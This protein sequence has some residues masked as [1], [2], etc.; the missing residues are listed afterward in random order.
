MIL[1]LILPR[2]GL[3]NVT[4]QHK[5]AA[6]FLTIFSKRARTL[7]RTTWRFVRAGIEAPAQV[8]PP[9][10]KREQATA[11]QKRFEDVFLQ[12]PIHL[13]KADQVCAGSHPECAFFQCHAARR[14]GVC[15]STVPQHQRD[16]W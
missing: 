13:P 7:N 14:H 2:I 9:C 16:E 8:N 1:G 5:R 3:E 15:A 11:N 4:E 12:E 10:D 6:T